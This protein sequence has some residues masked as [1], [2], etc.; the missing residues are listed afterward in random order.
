MKRISGIFFSQEFLRFLISGSIAAAVNFFSR[1]FFRLYFSY[2]LSIAFS[3]SLGTVISFF[4]NKFF[5]F[6]SFGEK[7]AI[8]LAKFIL[9]AVTSVILASFL[10]SVQVALYKFTRIN[11]IKEKNLESVVHL[12]TIGLV[13]VY[14]FLAMKYF[15]FRKCAEEEK[16]R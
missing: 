8:Q 12:T 13:T 6:R 9:I 2:A 3:F 16:A 14:N 10:A 4:L 1:F 7:S 5:T 15:S 11:F